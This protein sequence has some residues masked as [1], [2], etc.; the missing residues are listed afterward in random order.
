MSDVYL[1]LCT[2]P[3][4]E[5]ARQIGT[6]LV[7]RQL[8][9]CVNLMPSVQSIYRWNGKI[10]DSTEILAIFKTSRGQYPALESELIELHPY[11]VAEVIA[12]RPDQV[13]SLYERWVIGETNDG[14]AAD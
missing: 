6:V 1:V 9:A 8:A 2:F 14:L 7:E 5:Q 4:S 11:E 12:I 10:E 3:D 13:A